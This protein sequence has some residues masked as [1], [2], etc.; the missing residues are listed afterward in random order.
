MMQSLPQR[1]KGVVVMT[2][3][4]VGGLMGREMASRAITMGVAWWLG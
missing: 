4:S 2:P 1:G 3:L